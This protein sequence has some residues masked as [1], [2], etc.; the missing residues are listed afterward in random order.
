MAQPNSSGRQDLEILVASYC[1]E[2][3]EILLNRI[4]E[5]ATG[6]ISHFVSPF[7]FTSCREDLIQAG[8]E[9]L[10]KALKR[11]EPERKV[12][13]STYASYYIKGEIMRELQR[14][15]AYDKPPWL[16]EIQIKIYRANE[17]L[18]QSLQREPSLREIA[19]AINIKEEG[20]IQAMLAG[21]VPLEELDLTSIKSLRYESFRLPI[22]DQLLLREA[23]SKLS[24]VQ[25][26]IIYLIY[27]QDLTQTTVAE[28]LGTNQRRV[29]R[30][31][32]K[33]LEQLAV[34]LAS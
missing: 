13:F 25:Q 30:L 19:E 15:I 4:V 11:F 6:L 8:Y 14:G 9:G 32:K 12:R 16:A 24:E 26:K 33:S 17:E 3:S 34:H 10:L 7:S 28:L 2:P 29:S 20:V 31:L 18:S 1:Q 5:A 27:Y 21:N 23:L 22:E